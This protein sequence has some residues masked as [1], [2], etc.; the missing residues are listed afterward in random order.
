MIVKQIIDENLSPIWNK[1][2]AENSSPSSFLQ[3]WQWGKFKNKTQNVLRRY[4]I[5]DSEEL[6]A[7][8]QFLK[9]GLPGGKFYLNCQRGPVWRQQTTNNKQQ[10]T[11]ILNLL[12]EEI[13]KTAKKE[14]IVFVRIAPP[15]DENYELRIMNYGFQKP[16]ILVH[17]KEPENTLLVDLTKTEEEIL[18]GMHQKTR[19]NIKLAE[20]KGVKI[21]SWKPEDGSREVE[22][23]YKLL[24]ETAKRD[25]INIF[26]KAYY[27]NLVEFFSQNKEGGLEGQLFLAEF[28]NKILAAIFVIGFGDSATYFYGASGNEA[29][30]LMP[31]YLLQWTAIKWAKENGYKY[32][33]FWG[34]EAEGT[35]N[36]EGISRFKR[37][38]AG[39]K[40]G[41][42]MKY[43]GVYDCVLDKKWYNLYRIA[44][45]FKK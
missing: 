45:F 8:A 39:E 3:S 35:K 44:K 20:K 9:V 22:E 25:G 6:V 33:D 2:V 21:R 28:E 15:Y 12:V 4:A 16:Q 27:K 23:F 24:Q 13:K 40:T 29:R 41:K 11:E 32:Y 18:A 5:Y 10:T 17:L 38:F 7:V 42:E 26:G 43:F 34:I 1:F 31:N 36:W 19:Y 30:E 14:K 37:G